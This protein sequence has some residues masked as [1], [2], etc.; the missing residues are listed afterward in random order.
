MRER[1]DAEDLR[2]RLAEIGERR[3]RADV[4]ARPDAAPDQEHRHVLARVIGARRRR[5]VAV[6]GGDDQQIA[7]RAARQQ[8]RQPGVEA[9]EIGRV[10]GRVV[11]MAVLRVEVDEIGEDQPGTGRVAI[12][13]SI[14][15]IPSSSLFV[16]T[17]V[18]MPR[19]ANRSWILP[20]AWTGLAGRGH[21]VEQRASRDGG[22]A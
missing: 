9:L 2:D 12:A 17:A 8:A 13:F 10:A 19:P 22:S 21:R 16:W 6:I 15:S 7:R 1:T 14:S 5:I 20:I 3:A 11:A 18:V 4:G